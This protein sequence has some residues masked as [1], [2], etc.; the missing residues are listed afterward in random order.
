MKP[1]AESD[2]LRRA[3]ARLPEPPLPDT[4][5][6]Q[7]MERVR[8]E[9]ARR[10]RLETV[11][12]CL[13]GGVLL[14]LLLGG[15]WFMLRRMAPELSF[16]GFPALSAPDFTDRTLWIDSL[17]LAALCLLLLGAD[18]LLRRRLRTQRN[19]RQPGSLQ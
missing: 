8:R 12:L 19:R 7:L 6:V 1:T 10:A 15:A 17:R 3:I 14:A 2:T 11:G 16:P 5:R 18:T 13:T 4:F 9:A